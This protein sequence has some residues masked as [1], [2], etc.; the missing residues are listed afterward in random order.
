MKAECDEV[1][2]TTV[3][4]RTTEAWDAFLCWFSWCAAS[5]VFFL[6]LSAFLVAFLF[7]FVFHIAI[8]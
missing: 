4:G 3:N 6:A 1:T 2:E 7:L 5:A 8:E